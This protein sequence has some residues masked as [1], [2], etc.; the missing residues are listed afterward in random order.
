MRVQGRFVVVLLSALVLCAS[1]PADLIF[2]KDGFVLQGKVKREGT[3]TV[4]NGQPVW[5][6]QGFFLI[7]ADCRRLYFSPGQVQDVD[8]K[9]ANTEIEIKSPVFIAANFTSALPP[10]REVI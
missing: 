4:D 5:M 10:L 1:A 2:L 6:P 9:N 7:D 3:V 8:A